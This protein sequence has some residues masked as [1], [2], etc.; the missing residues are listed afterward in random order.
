M[1]RPATAN[2]T[3][4]VTAELAGVGSYMISMGHR[5]EGT[6]DAERLRR[7]FAEVVGRHD[8]LRTGFAVQ[9]AAVH[10]LVFP[11]P[12]FSYHHTTLADAGPEA[13]RAWALARVFDGVRP[14]DPSTLVRLLAAEGPGY[15][16][17]AVALHHA[18]SD[19]FS[20]GVV[21]KELLKLYAGET[22]PA[23]GSYFTFVDG[24][25]AAPV[26]DSALAAFTAALPGPARIPADGRAGAGDDALGLFVEREIDGV[27]PGIRATAKATGATKFGVLSAVYALGLHAFTGETRLSSFFQSEGRR[28][29]GAPNSVVGPFSNTLPLDLSVEP[30]LA[31]GDFAR[32]MTERVHATLSHETA[33]VL[34][35]VIGARKAPNVSLNMFPP[36]ARIRAGTLQVGPREFLDRRTEYDLNLV[37]TEDGGVLRGRGFYDA[38]QLSAERVALF[39]DLQARL[40]AAVLDDPERPCRQIVEAARAGRAARLPAA[41]AGAPPDG[42]IHDAFFARAAADPDAPAIITSNGTTSYGALRAQALRI[43]AALAG[44]GVAAEK[45]VAILTGRGPE[46]V[47]A[48]L[49]VSAAGASFAV[50]DASYPAE[51]VAAMLEVLGARRVICADGGLAAGLPEHLEV[52]SPADAQDAQRPHGV[53]RAQAYHLF[54]SGTTG[55]PKRIT[56]PDATL[57]RFVAW[58]AGRMTGPTPPRTMM[59]AGLSHDPVMRDIF[60]PLSTGGAVAIPDSA[61]MA[62]PAAL[63]RLLRQARADIVHLTPASGRLLTLGAGAGET[64]GH[65]R[66]VV[67]GGDVLSPGTVTAWRRRAPAAR[68]F[69]LYGTSETPQAALIHEVAGADLAG[70]RVP[71][72]APVP[73]TGVRLEDGHGTPVGP[74][75]LGEIVIELADPVLGAHDGP[76]GAAGR[77]AQVHRT[78]DLGVLMPRTG[79]HFIGRRDG[80]VKLNSIR[81][82]LSEVAAQAE[83]VPGVHQAEALLSE[84]EGAEL[85]LFAVAGQAEVTDASLRA[86]LHRAL[87]GSMVPGRVHLLD[88]LPVTPNGKIDKAALMAHDAAARAAPRETRSP[89]S[90]HTETA[91]AAILSQ[92]SG[93]N[94]DDSTV[95]L[96]DLG[97]DSL[98]VIETRIAL[99]KLGLD[100]PDGWEWMSV[101][102]LAGHAGARIPTP[103]SLPGWVRPIRLDS[104]IALRTLA[105]AYIVAHHSGIHKFGGGSVMLIALA[106][107]AFGR[108]QLP[109]I[110]RDDR[111]GRLWALLVKLLVPLVPSAL[112]IFAVHSYV[113]N[114]PHPSAVLFYENLSPFID[115]VLLQKVNT[116][117]HITLLWFLHA[118]LQLFLVIAVLLTFARLRTAAAADPWRATLIFA[119]AAEGVA[120]GTVLAAG[121]YDGDLGHVAAMLRGSP[122]TLMPVLA[123]GVLVAL[124][125]TSGRRVVA[126]ALA[127]VHFALGAIGPL[128][129]DEGLWLLALAATILVPYLSVPAAGSIVLIAI[130]AHAL[131]IYLTHRAV[132]FGLT[133]A[134][135][136]RPPSVVVLIVALGT[137]VALGIGLRPVLRRLGVN[138]L[139]E[140]RLSI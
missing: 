4:Y 106:G 18:N 46:M 27:S 23:P 31:F 49:G 80:Q 25:Q 133:A 68:Q 109:A 15:W 98:S 125:D 39:L 63:R 130:S 66:V 115:T 55:R 139:A 107:F 54:T 95:C 42:C 12:H 59:V 135:G 69:N 131:M 111:T 124:S 137:G 105:I 60:L 65:V 100:L 10:A 75:E 13:F 6:L 90:G 99:E 73:W 38:R 36:A 102:A 3:R 123:I 9:G 103:R 114:S 71:V 22:L 7:A 53:A 33:P 29:V 41:A 56:H 82:E 127:L 110:L 78:G 67:W 122:T 17:F 96:A 16:R 128:G 112:L 118:Y 93:L 134:F 101:A 64:F 74:G 84:G 26:D 11:E 35:H 83:W 62:D 40:I 126:A 79:V 136:E 94:V 37:W 24:K 50:I 20:R 76:H 61:E 72:G 86:A 43:A 58:Q 48:M 116:H 32:L 28:A 47:A 8:A 70:Q 19:G 120:V 5:V 77:P 87:P 121:A 132:S 108:L 51:R 97:A 52:L 85:C 2:Q 44:A 138:R 140:R 21:N 88:R 45:P 119:L 30:D 113:G 1:P 89:L 117:H 91:I 81:I 129:G 92:N 104:F 34:D 57:M 14:G